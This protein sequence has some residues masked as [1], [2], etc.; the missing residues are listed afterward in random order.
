MKFALLLLTAAAALT[1]TTAIKCYVCKEGLEP[2]EC[3]HTTGQQTQCPDN[4]NTCYV[5][6]ISK[7]AFKD[8]FIS[9]L[10][11]FW[12]ILP[13]FSLL[14]VPGLDGSGI[15]P[16]MTLTPFLSSVLLDEIRTHDPL[17]MIL[18]T[19]PESNKNTFF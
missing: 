9:F 1:T 5:R 11:V 2:D 18:P 7:D 6:Q 4:V 16:D 17:I 14:N 10:M 19:R 12:A 8:A 3:K 13:I 15:N